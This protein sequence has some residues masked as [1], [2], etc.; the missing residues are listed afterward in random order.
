MVFVIVA[1]LLQLH[2][3]VTHFIKLSLQIVCFVHQQL[4]LMQVVYLIRQLLLDTFNCLIQIYLII[5][6]AHYSLVLGLLF[7]LHCSHSFGIGIKF[8]AGLH[9]GLCEFDHEAIIPNSHTLICF[10]VHLVHVS[11]IYAGFF[12]FR[13]VPLLA[14]VN[15]F[16]LFAEQK[17]VL[18]NFHY[19]RL[20]GFAHICDRV[21]DVL[22]PHASTLCV[23]LKKYIFELFNFQRMVFK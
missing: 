15:L 14:K 17:K 10:L 3:S 23:T 11:N 13:F 8:L 9:V 2:V 18:F 22:E 4:C 21:I 7:C 5:Y 1:L 12:D 16:I 6:Y 19:F 20:E